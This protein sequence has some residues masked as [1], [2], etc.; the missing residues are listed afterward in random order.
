MMCDGVV[1]GPGAMTSKQ[2]ADA[3]DELVSGEKED[4]MKAVAGCLQIGGLVLQAL[5]NHVEMCR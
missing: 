3:D 1:G 2:K 4:A 5:D